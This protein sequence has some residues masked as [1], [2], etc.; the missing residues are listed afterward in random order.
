MCFAFFF[1]R[2]S[3]SFVFVHTLFTTWEKKFPIFLIARHE[4]QLLIEK[5]SIFNLCTC[6]NY[7]RNWSCWDDFFLIKKTF[8]LVEHCFA[9][10]GSIIFC[11]S[12]QHVHRLLRQLFNEFQERCSKLFSTLFAQSST[13][14]LLHFLSAFRAHTNQWILF[15]SFEHCANNIA[16]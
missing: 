7:S 3:F 16:V 14:F 2:W 8:R 4:A 9:I 1:R 6:R 11:L 15:M 13:Q 10:T 5:S 12:T